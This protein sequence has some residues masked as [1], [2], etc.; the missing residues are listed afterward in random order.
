MINLKY[1]PCYSKYQRNEITLIQPTCSLEVSV[2]EMAGWPTQN[3]TCCLFE[4][5]SSFSSQPQ[6]GRGSGCFVEHN[7]EEKW[8]AVRMRVGSAGQAGA[9]WSTEGSMRCSV[10]FSFFPF[11]VWIQVDLLRKHF[12]FQ[13]SREALQ[14]PRSNRKESLQCSVAP[15]S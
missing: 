7:I 9:G 12:W 1:W 13:E 10:S 3:V 4:T 15:R 11:P 2:P 5:F 6:G 14:A 8:P